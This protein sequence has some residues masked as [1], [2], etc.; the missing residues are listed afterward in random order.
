MIIIHT[1]RTNKRE[2]YLSEALDNLVLRYGIEIHE[3]ADGD[4]Q[5]PYI[6]DGDKLISGKKSLNDWLYELKKELK[7]Q[8]SVSGDGCYLDPDTGETC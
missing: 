1:L 3:E 5:F 2:N 6:T 4:H 7:W 8:R